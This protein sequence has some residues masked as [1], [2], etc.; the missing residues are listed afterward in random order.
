ML[1]IE[2]GSQKRG[3]FNLSSDRDLLLIGES[4]T[5]LLKEKKAKKA[6][7]YSV[8]CLPTDKAKYMIKKGSLF[9]KHIIDEG[10]LVEG[11]DQKY[12]DII[13]NWS[14]PQDYNE[15]IDGNI[16][17]LEILSCVPKTS[18]GILVA[19]DIVTISIRNILIRKLALI[20]RYVFSWSE[21]SN[22]AININT[23]DL[24]DKKILLHARQIKNYYRQG[25]DSQ[26]SEFFLERL[27]I[28]LN[29]ILGTKIYYNFGNKHNITKLP[30]K[31][32]NGTYKQ[33]RSIELLCAYY[34]FDSSPKQFLE[35]VKDPNYFSNTSNCSLTKFTSCYV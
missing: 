19:T 15:E 23:I 6:I 30:E 14:A 25:Y 9:F 35:W 29:K 32:K 20:G 2:F 21:V 33:L 27:L 12:Y 1:S 31:C 34:G 28:I 13:N 22:A 5:K 4:F 7:G 8:T 11:S 24:N 18:E 10:C 16:E 17:L 26:V 3:D